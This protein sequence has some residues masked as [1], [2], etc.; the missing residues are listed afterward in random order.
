[1]TNIEVLKN[2]LSEIKKYLIIVK[3]YQTKSKEDMIKDQTLR[4]AI[5]RYLYLLCQST[6]D[7]SEALISHFDFRQP[8][9]YGEIFEILNERKIISNNIAKR[10]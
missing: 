10:F 3:S 5:E 6:I 4:G 1:M 7:F 2:K 8:S 9:T